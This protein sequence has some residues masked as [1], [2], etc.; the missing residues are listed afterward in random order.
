MAGYQRVEEGL[1]EPNDMSPQKKS[2]LIRPPSISKQSSFPSREAMEDGRVA[3]DIMKTLD[4]RDAKKN[5]QLAI[6]KPHQ[7]TAK[8]RS[9]G[10]NKKK[11]SRFYKNESKP[12]ARVQSQPTIIRPGYTFEK[13]KKPPPRPPPPKCN[14]FGNKSSTVCP[15]SYEDVIKADVA[16]FLGEM[17]VPRPTPQVPI[18]PRP[19]VPKQARAGSMPQIT[20]PH[21]P[22]QRP[23]K[24][25]P[26][27]QS[28]P[29]CSSAVLIDFDATASPPSVDTNSC[30][31]LNSQKNVLD[32][33]KIFS[34][35]ELQASTNESSSPS[36][37]AP[38]KVLTKL[39][40]GPRLLPPGPV[41]SLQRKSSNRTSEG[42]LSLQNGTNAQVSS[43]GEDWLLSCLK[44]TVNGDL[45][46]AYN[47][48]IP[49]SPNYQLSFEHSPSDGRSSPSPPL[50]PRPTSSDLTY[51]N[52]ELRDSKDLTLNSPAPPLSPPPV[53]PLPRPG[54][55]CISNSIE[56]DPPPL[57]PRPKPFEIRPHAIALYDYT[58]SQG[59]ELSFKANEIITLIHHVNSEWLFGYTDEA[60]GIFPKNF[61]RIMVPLPGS[62]LTMGPRCLAIYDFEG[63]NDKELTFSAGEVIALKSRENDEWFRGSLNGQSGIFP[64]SYVEIIEDLCTKDGHAISSYTPVNSYIA[65]YDFIGEDGELSFREGEKITA[66]E[67]INEQWML[68]K[69]ENGLKGRFPKTFVIPVS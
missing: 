34:C 66:M 13:K 8:V 41:P 21:L 43:R 5:S 12:K 25:L 53:P 45:N 69:L 29:S 14:Q 24:P 68:G 44:N 38:S 30:Q 32:L 3:K 36:Q 50:P 7:D 16:A 62:E 57:P 20:P 60:E 26:R 10:K 42:Q 58:A 51:S 17:S 2:G 54:F 63:E 35:N 61:V 4:E 39:N 6:G 27:M 37:S 67:E 52:L 1:C 59:D 19:P 49:L 9:E 23:P 65:L 18:R 28:Q 33:D 47:S 15:P 40:L 22:N 48:D 64:A 31:T 46:T 11:S 56:M 55:A